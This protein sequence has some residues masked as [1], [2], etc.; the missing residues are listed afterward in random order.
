[1]K[2]KEKKFQAVLSDYQD[3]I[4][5]LC[6]SYV[7]D[8][9]ARKDLYQ[10]IL[11]RLWKGIESFENRSLMSTWV[12]RIAVNSS[13]DFLRSEF[14]KK[15]NSKHI[16]INNLE[17]ADKSNNLEEDFIISERTRL[18][19]KCI[20]KLSFVDK[21]IISLYLEDLSYRNIADIVGISAK[22]V[23]VKL[24]RIKKILNKYL[25]DI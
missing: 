16:D 17:I 7:E 21:T 9:D 13:L 22:N 11:I 15:P 5:R 3:M 14:G 12:Y 23:S 8:Y 18:M 24:Y 1:M 4:Y 20:N 19:Y 10:N 6:C 2:N 25:K